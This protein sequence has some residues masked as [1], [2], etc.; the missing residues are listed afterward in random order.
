MLNRRAM[1][2]STGAA[3]AA[4][5]LAPQALA[6][7]DPQLSALFDSFFKEGLQQRPESA[8][9]LGLD[10]GANAGLKAKLDDG[11]SAGRA[12]ARALNADQLRRPTARSSPAPTG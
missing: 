1:L 3:A 8:T 7:G 5:G 10:K 2:L 6:V 12:A 4:V 11:S 9:Q